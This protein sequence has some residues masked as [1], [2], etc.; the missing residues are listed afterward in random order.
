M[1]ARFNRQDVVLGALPVGTP[2]AEDVFD[3][4]TASLDL[5]NEPFDWDVLAPGTTGQVLTANADG[6]IGWAASASGFANPMTTAGD[7][8]I[9]GASGAGARLGIGSTNQ[10]LTVVAGAP[11]WAAASGGGGTPGGTS[12]QIQ[13]DNGGSFGGFTMSGDATLVTS[14]GVI[15]VAAGAITLAKQ[16]NFAASSLMGNPTGSS[17]A[18]SAI[19]LGAN[20]SFSGTTLVATAGTGTVTSVSWTGDGTIFTASADTP[21]T[22]SGTLTPASLIAQTAHYVLAGPASAGPTAP[23]FRALVAADV[24]NL[25]A[26]QITSGQLAIAQGGT[27]AS[28]TAAARTNLGLEQGNRTFGVSGTPTISTATP[29]IY[30]PTAVTCI[31]AVA[32]CGT[33][34]TGTATITL[35]TAPDGTTWSTLV[36]VSI[37]TGNYSGTAAVTTAIS[38]GTWVRGLF[39]AVNGVANMTTTLYIEG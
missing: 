13:Y 20:L 5:P 6:S 11:A 31:S 35:Q 14:T 3:E 25:P 37:T 2:V 10:V 29:P 9:G 23:T 16:A 4:S 1:G 34:P 21:V 18:P 15:T 19:S 28:T 33:A 30:L 38:A 22:T 27:A 39:T 7:V 26:S 17:A 36:A 32:A 12:G 24:P 8:I